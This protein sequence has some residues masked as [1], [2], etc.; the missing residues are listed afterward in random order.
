[1]IE[2]TQEQRRELTGPEPIAIDPTTRAEYVLVPRA[3][4]E[5]LRGLLDDDTVLATGDLLDRVMAKDD[6]HD[7]YLESYQSITREDQR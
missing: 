6:A 3:V 4:Y 2:L 1:M 7:P 5:R